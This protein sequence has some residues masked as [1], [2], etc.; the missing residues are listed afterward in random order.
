[1]NKQVEE[2]IKLYRAFQKSPLLFIERVWGLKPERDNDKF[3]KGEHL[4]WQQHD[5]LLAIESAL[6]GDKPKRISVASGHGI[7]KTATL[8]WL[9]LWYLYCFKD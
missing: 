4:S 8:S 6:R 1:M 3:I 5:I 2:D 9:L 7:G